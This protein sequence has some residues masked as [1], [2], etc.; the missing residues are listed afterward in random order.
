MKP[1]KENPIY[2]AILVDGSTQ[3]DITPVLTSV[4]F[5]DQENQLAKSATLTLANIQVGGKWLNTIVRARQRLFIYADDGETKDEVFRGV[6][7][8]QYYKSALSDREITVQAYDNLI[9]FQESEDSLFFSEGKSTSEVLKSICQSWGVKLSYGYESITNPK[10]VLRGAL[11]DIIINDVLEPVRERTGKK[12]VIL[13]VKDTLT[14]KQIGQNSTVYQIKQKENSLNT[15]SEETMDGMITKVVILGKAESGDRPPVE[16]V[17][18]GNTSQYGTMQK[19]Y[20]RDENTSLANARTEA[21][22]MIKDSGKPAWEYQVQAADIPWLRKG[23]KVFVNAGSLY[24]KYF[25]AASIERSITNKAKTMN[26]TLKD[27]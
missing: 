19:L 22:N 4:D 26:L 16:A 18:S 7:W 20:D 27:V 13:S 17:V 5:S 10:L 6:I 24:Q 9:Y 23:D 14:I 25:I 8:T 3:Y 1:S 2:T 11:S 15:R 21:N 12:Y